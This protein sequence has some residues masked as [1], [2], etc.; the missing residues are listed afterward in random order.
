MM[1]TCD[2]SWTAIGL[3][4]VVMACGGYSGAEINSEAQT[5]RKSDV[6]EEFVL[7]SSVWPHRMDRG[8]RMA[9]TLK[10]SAW[11]GAIVL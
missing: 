2:K 7:S 4:L 3:R 5:R 10:G 1:Q 11:D 9:K 8:A 6:R